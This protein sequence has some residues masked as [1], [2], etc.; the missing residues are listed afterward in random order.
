[1]Q[2]LR[3]FCDVALHRSFSEAAQLHGISQSAASQRVHQLEEQLGVTLIDR[4]VRPLALTDAGKVLMREGRDIVQRYD[5]LIQKLSQADGRVRGE[6][7]VD[8]IYSAGI[9]LLVNLKEEFESVHPGIRLRVDYKRPEQVHDQVRTGQCDLGIVSYPHRWKDVSV[10]PLRDERMSVVCSPR[11]ALAGGAVIHARELSNHSMVTFES[12]LPVGRAIRR[13]LKEHGSSPT[14]TN[15]F[16]N[17]DT[18]KH[19]VSVTDDLTILP[20]R[21]VKRE[22]ESGTL[23]SIQLEPELTRPM[24]VIGPK[25]SRSNGKSLSPAAQAFV[26]FLVEFLA[27]LSPGEGLG[28]GEKQ[29]AI[30][31]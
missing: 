4:S 28:A 7:V 20:T 27:P 11:H 29:K 22:V 2:T 10:V 21:T 24:G 30:Q 6:V 3:L 1:M 14:I 16:D 17:I 8:A 18:I 19:A 9:D 13:Y 26:E 25:R 15:M 31:A 12:G 23:A 5:A